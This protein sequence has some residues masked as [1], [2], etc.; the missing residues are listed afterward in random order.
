M[1]ADAGCAPPPRATGGD[2]KRGPAAR[3]CRTLCVVFIGRQ[4]ACTAATRHG[5]ACRRASCHNAEISDTR[6]GR[7]RTATPGRPSRCTAPEAR[8]AQD[9]ELPYRAEPAR[10]TS[11]APYATRGER[12]GGRHPPLYIH[13][14]FSGEV[15]SGIGHRETI[16]GKGQYRESVIGEDQH[17]EGYHRGGTIWGRAVS[18]PTKRKRKCRRKPVWQCSA[19]RARG[20]GQCSELSLG[21]CS[22]THP[23]P[24]SPRRPDADPNRGSGSRQR[25]SSKSWRSG[26]AESRLQ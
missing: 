18:G 20:R 25:G 11:E 6:R 7:D 15:A 9:G 10:L 14:R 12:G 5:A 13:D 22:P 16:I 3:R 17:R 2:D 1:R 8:R 19:V 23:L 24:P 26:R 4:E 21:Q